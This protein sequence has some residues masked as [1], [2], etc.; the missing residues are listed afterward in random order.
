M[1]KA[2][3]VFE[4]TQITNVQYSSYL[5]G[6]LNF[7]ILILLVQKKIKLRDKGENKTQIM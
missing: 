5:A 7:S 4:Q 2:T 3:T 6:Y 1:H